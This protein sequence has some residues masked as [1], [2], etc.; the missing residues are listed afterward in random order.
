MQQID[1]ELN[2]AQN[3]MLKKINGTGLVALSFENMALVEAMI[4]KDSAYL[5]SSD[6]KE[7]PV[8]KKIWN[9]EGRQRGG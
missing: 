8:V 7:K 4:Q 5:K 2:A 9:T 6:E 1:R 3:Y